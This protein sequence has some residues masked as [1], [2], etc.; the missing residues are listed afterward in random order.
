MPLPRLALGRRRAMQ[1]G[2]L[3]PAHAQA[4]PHPSV[5]HAATGRHV[6][7]LER[8]RGQPAAARGH[9]SAHRGCDERRLDR[10][11]LVHHRGGKQLPRNHR[12]RRRY[13]ALLLHPRLAAHVFQ[14]HLRRARG[15]AVHERRG[16]TRP[17]GHRG[18]RDAR[19]DVGRL[20]LR[21]VLH[22]RRPD[23]PLPNRR[24]AIDSDQLPLSRSTRIPLCC[25]TASS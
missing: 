19:H 17:R 8:P 13:G 16:P 5:D 18:R 6:V 11:A 14:E 21:P 15:D 20:L 3:Q 25:N 23:L 1:A 10:L 22:D 9:D 4:G 7:R 24:C 12:Q 2:A